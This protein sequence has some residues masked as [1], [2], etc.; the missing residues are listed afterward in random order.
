MIRRNYTTF[1]LILLL[2]FLSNA[3]AGS[4]GDAP[5]EGQDWV[6]TQDTHVWDD[7]VNVKDIVVTIGKTLKLE[8][9]SLTSIGSIQIQGETEWLNSTISHDKRDLGDNISLYSKLEIINTKLLMNATDSYDGNNANVLYVNKE[10][11]LII[12]DYDNDETTTSDRSII[13]GI[14]AHA[15]G[16]DNRNN[17]SII[18]GHCVKVSC[19][20]GEE[21]SDLWFNNAKFSV[22]NSYFE[23]AYAIRLFGKGGKI[24]NT[25]FSNI[26]YVNM[27]G[28]DTFFSN[29]LISNSWSAYDFVGSGMNI[30]VRNN[31]FDNGT[32]GLHL[33]S[34]KPCGWLTNEAVIE[35]NNFL[36]YNQPA[37][38][39]SV[40]L[41][42]SDGNNHTVKHN[43]FKNI[44]N[45][46]FRFNAVNDTVFTNNTFEK[47]GLN[48]HTGVVKAGFRNDFNNNSFISIR[49]E[50]SPWF[51][52]GILFM[53]DTPSN[54][55]GGDHN[56]ADNSF[57]D[58][59]SG[60][61]FASYQNNVTVK[62]N[63][64]EKG[65]HAVGLWTWPDAATTAASGITI[66]KNT[67]NNTN[68]PIAL[69]YHYGGNAGFDNLIISNKITNTANRA[70][71]V[72]S[73]YKNFT[74]MDN[75]IENATEGV[76]IFDNLWGQISNGIVTE[77]ILKNITGNGISAYTSSTQTMENI[78]I[79]NNYIHSK[80]GAGIFFR[81]V[82][83]GYIANNTILTNLSRESQLTGILGYFIPDTIIKNNSV[84]SA[85]GIEV[86]G[87]VSS[88]LPIVIDGNNLNVNDYGIISNRTY[89]KIINN[90][91]TGFCEHD[92]C[93]ILYLQKVAAV[94]IF[95]QE[96]EVDVIN[97][98]I[99][100][101]EE[102]VTILLAEFKIE[103]NRINFSE[104]GIIANNSYG[105][106]KTNT[107]TNTTAAL[108]SHL[109][110]IDINGNL[111][112]DFEEAIYSLNSSL[113]I[114]DNFFS[115]GDS[116]IELID[117]DYEIITNDLQCRNIEYQVRYNIRLHITDESGVETEDHAFEIF[118]SEGDVIIDS[119]TSVY[120]LSNFFQ[121][122]TIRKN[123]GE[124]I[125]NFNPFKIVYENNNVP[126]IVH[127]NITFNH[128]IELVL[129][130]RAPVTVIAPGD[131]LIKEQTI[132]FEILLLE[133]NN[134][135]MDY[136]IEYLVNDEFAE[137]EVYGTFA[138]TSISFD[139]E[140]GKEYRFR[141]L[142]RDIYGNYESK[143]IYEYQVR[144]DTTTPETYFNSFTD[145]YYFTG[146]NV[147]DLSWTAN[148]LDISRQ[149]LE[150][151]YT[152]FTDPYLNPN[153]VTWLIIEN[154]EIKDYN[155]HKYEL[156]NVGHYAF[157]ILSEDNAGNLESKNRFDIIFNYDSDSD[158][159]N[160]GNIPTRWG[161]DS[162]TIDYTTSSFN[163]DFDLFISLEAISDK[164]DYLTWYKYEYTAESNSITLNGLQDDTRYY[165]YAVSRDLAGNVEDPLN[166]TE[167][168][169]ST[170]L[171]DQ[172][173]E[174]KYIPLLDWGYDLQVHADD[175]LDGIY[176]TSL[177]R[178]D[179]QNR[180]KANEY[181]LDIVNNKI[182]FGGLTNGG[183]VP[184]E[185]LYSTNNIRVV[186]SGVQGIFEVYTGEPESANSLN[187]VPSNTTELVVSFIVPND[188]NSCK[189]QRSTNIS[190]GYFNEMIIQPC[191]A[192]LVEYIHSNPDLDEIYYYR[193]L[194]EDEF[195]HESISENRS[196]DMKDVVKLYSST[197]DSNSSLLGMDSIIPITALVGIIMLGFGG[198]L[199]YRSRNDDL[200]DDNVTIIET[201][202]V[203]KYKVE[204]L[205]LIY[206]D[207]R[208]LKNLSDVEVKTD[209]DIMSGMLTAINDFVQD[210]FNTEGD[211]GS[212]DYGNNKIIL[213]RGAN[214][215][216]AAVI[217]G[218]VDKFFKGK[219]INAVRNIENVNPTMNNWNGDAE[220][221]LHTE[222]YLQ[223]IIDETKQSTKEMVDN[224]FSEKEIVLTTSY[225]K[226]GDVIELQVHMSNYSSGGINNCKLI[227][228]YNSL[229]LSLT[230]IDPDVLYSFID[231]SFMV[232]D[233][234]S[235]N[236]V[237]FLLKFQMKFAGASPL[238]IK[239]NYE[240]KGRKGVA[241]S[242][243]E[244]I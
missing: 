174:L 90:N 158:T 151:Y 104:F 33:W 165:F 170:G 224:Y 140:D 157:K 73:T 155:N 212:I 179:D 26:G 242:L 7:E 144:I 98:N 175:D 29:N 17:H 15:Q 208:L 78:Q 137:W 207:G 84:T 87:F 47:T 237:T 202:P 199:L 37:W 115:D 182:L 143:N 176:E 152:N 13:K 192:G 188:S 72:W 70:I 132:T 183:F 68:Y 191:S 166:A 168:Y 169:S 118:N 12:R 197:D 43:T 30:A 105:E 50:W 122:D 65:F 16:F 59:A 4:N 108:S 82:N 206:K 91:V 234:E 231:N 94:G 20:H 101:F 46:A 131:S 139:G 193:I 126:V 214:S 77:N 227:P 209:S 49:H 61:R 66:S 22:K 85:V 186:Y 213:Q 8:N 95:S 96:G 14:N 156:G 36:N 75:Y 106:L 164:T 178:G 93:N 6:I 10:A 228:E 238:E 217:Y 40:T 109:S 145:D 133:D 129:D 67:I 200:V 134:D 243:L 52:S 223:P 113:Q 123:S 2:F 127:K 102:S 34:C 64:F 117:S 21:D 230:G 194:I 172:S 41:Q 53:Y 128:T 138:E 32:N 233:I 23:N 159:L 25:H 135:I 83:K 107:I 216:L 232:G 19:S 148:D 167:Y 55:W 76:W 211:L 201:K 218:E 60:I 80:N 136:T 27:V 225:E 79:T 112:R 195:G 119:L 11:E 153:S 51:V 39:D 42:I 150:V 130:T 220:T 81:D 92:R 239:M 149:F 177:V 196:I 142:G 198:V 62:N 114:E 88:V 58:F 185:D 180:L 97:N 162:L 204:E 74:I 38:G 141:S 116:C 3:S 173:I 161:E 219:L 187:I 235:Y 189:V 69:D 1:A 110:T 221:I 120:G 89:T 146:S 222:H 5:Q 44:S 210:S 48:A 190:K 103:D 171:Y 24:E 160:F 9:V 226:V 100:N 163:L 124:N 99:S 57:H 184:N 28:N 147:L 244:I 121:V 205:Y 45:H 86:G 125:V 236:E 31:T 54:L 63:T 203:A 241:N 181:F 56:I 111:F 71:V 240:Q 215:Y 35:N 154:L 229:N 18:I